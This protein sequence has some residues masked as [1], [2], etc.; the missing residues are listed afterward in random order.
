M[1]EILQLRQVS[2]DYR[3]IFAVKD[4]DFSL[5]KGEVHALLGENGAGK[6]TLTKIVAGAVSPSSGEFLFEGKS[7]KFDAPKDA[8]AAGT[9][10]FS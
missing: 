4:V 5:V 8:I 10:L 7:V 9:R 1:S 6:S 3:G 2:K